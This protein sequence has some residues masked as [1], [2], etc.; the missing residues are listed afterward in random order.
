[1]PFPCLDLHALLQCSFPLHL[2][3]VVPK[4]GQSTEGDS[5]RGAMRTAISEGTAVAVR[6]AMEL[7]E[8]ATGRPTSLPTRTRSTI[9]EKAMLFEPLRCD[10][11]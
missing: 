4:T 1:M 6:W 5:V 2:L 10:C 3:Q 8:R 11:T 7:Q 9:S